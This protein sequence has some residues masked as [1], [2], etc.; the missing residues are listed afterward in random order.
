[1]EELTE[2]LEK[3]KR[4]MF[5]TETHLHTAEVSRCGKLRAHQLVAA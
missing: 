2:R 3:E 1:M 4:G 5:K